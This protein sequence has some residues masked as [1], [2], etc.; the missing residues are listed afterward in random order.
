MD[1]ISEAIHEAWE[2]LGPEILANPLELNKRLARRR[3][4]LHRRPPRA[5]C[6]AVRACDTRITPAAAIIVPEDAAYPGRPDLYR[7]HQVTLDARLLRRLCKP[8]RIEPPGQDWKQVADLLGVHKN[9]LTDAR[10][11]GVFQVH[12]IKGLAGQQGK[13]IP[14]L[15]S[16]EDFDPSGGY[17][18]LKADP[19]WLNVWVW[20][21]DGLKDDF[22]D[23]VMREPVERPMRGRG[24]FAGWRWRCRGCGRLVR[25]VYCPLDVMN[26]PRFYGIDP[27]VHEFDQIEPVPQIF[28]CMEC[29]GVRHFSRMDANGWGELVHHFSGGLLYGFEV[30]KPAW[31]T[32]DRK[33]AF[34]P[35]INRPPSKRREEVLQRMLKGWKYQRIA[36]DLGLSYHRTRNLAHV[37]LKHHRAH[38]RAELIQRL[39]PH[40][41]ADATPD[42]IG[43]PACH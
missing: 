10:K 15:Y 27:A 38:G 35:M 36:K 14:V 26:L 22:E 12:Y 21:A 37:I 25:I 28:A 39:R 32:R 41:Q 31:L 6:L 42:G 17:I 5:W 8:V 40:L 9:G 1:D 3:M 33:R 20:L 24:V 4:K 19:V 43:P 18:G 29:H 11:R 13:P 2:K 7:E 30:K 16:S 34:K 23:T